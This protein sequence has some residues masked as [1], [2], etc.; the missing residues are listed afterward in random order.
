MQVLVRIRP[1]APNERDLG[2]F[3]TAWMEFLTPRCP[4]R[5]TIATSQVSAPNG[6]HLIA[7]G[8]TLNARST[9]GN[10]VKRDSQTVML[11]R[12]NQS[13]TLDHVA[14]QG[15]S[16]ADIFQGG[17]RSAH[18]AS[19]SNKPHYRAGQ[20]LPA[21]CTIGPHCQTAITKYQSPALQ[22]R[23]FPSWTT[24]RRATMPR[25]LRMGRRAPERLS[26]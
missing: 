19:P 18:V 22:L 2:A 24:W 16:Q 7:P 8:P 11:R 6:V 26:P 3:P 20:C 15:D 23:G 10:V 9:A 12:E 25:C 21:D 5:P 14:G 13:F 1:S 17:P 4:N